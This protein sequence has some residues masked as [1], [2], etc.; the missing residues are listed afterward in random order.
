L[1]SVA[2][3]VSSSGLPIADSRA[4]P[5]PP[6][7]LVAGAGWNVRYPAEALVAICRCARGACTLASSRADAGLP[8]AP[9]GCGGCRFS[10]HLL[11]GILDPADE[12]VSGQRRDVL[13][14]IQCRR[15]GDQRLAQVCGKLVH[16]PTGHSLAAAHRATVAVQGP[17]CF[18]NAAAPIDADSG[19]EAHQLAACGCR[20][21]VPGLPGAAMSARRQSSA[22]ASWCSTARAASS[23][24]SGLR[25]W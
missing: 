2:G 24:G 17:A 5:G 12:L 19:A 16:Y 14:G 13:P 1:R 20:R 10:G 7:A 11:L 8:P 6:V 9:P 21:S 22:M 23:A 25:A 15:A 4:V 3:S 18:T